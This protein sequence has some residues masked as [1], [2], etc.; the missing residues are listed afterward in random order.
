MRSFLRL[1]YLL[2]EHANPLCQ[3]EDLLA[4]VCGRE[5]K[6]SHLPPLGYGH[7]TVT[8]KQVGHMD[9]W[10]EVCETASPYSTLS[11]SS[12]TVKVDRP[13]PCVIGTGTGSCLT[14]KRVISFYCMTAA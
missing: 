2:L 10:Q 14:W 8:K 6:L 5:G 11:I 7:N 3:T 4:L 9:S 12:V 13:F 1:Q